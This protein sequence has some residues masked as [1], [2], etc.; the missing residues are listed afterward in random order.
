MKKNITS[1]ARTILLT[2]HFF[3]ILYFINISLLFLIC[4]VII[5]QVVLIC[6]VI[7]E[8][9]SY[10]VILERLSEILFVF[11]FYKRICILQPVLYLSCVYRINNIISFYIAFIKDLFYYHL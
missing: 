5:I 1:A 4:V 11:V 9:L 10:T 7:W 2:N 6:F 8:R 3:F